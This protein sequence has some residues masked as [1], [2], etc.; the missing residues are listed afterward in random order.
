MIHFLINAA[1]E[2]SMRSTAIKKAFGVF[3]IIIL[4]V[5]MLTSCSSETQETG[6][7]SSEALLSPEEKDTSGFL[8]AVED[9]PDTVD[10]QCTSIHYTVALNVFD[11]L[12]ELQQNHDGSTQIVPSLAES[13]KVSDD[14]LN[15]SFKLRDNVKF[16]NGSSLTSSDV[17]YTFT[18]LLTNPKSCNKDI[19]SFIKGADELMQGKTNVLEGFRVIDDR[20]FVITLK[21]PFEAFFDCLCM[22]GASIMDE[23]TTKEAGDL[24]GIDPEYTV[25]TGPFIFS[26]WNPDGLILTANPDCFSGPP[27]SAGLDLRF[28]TE[29]EEQRKMFEDGEL[30]ILDLDEMGDSAEFFIHGDIYQDRLYKVQQIGIAYFALNESVEPLNDIRV[31]KALQLSLDRQILLDAVY[32]GRGAVENGIYPRGLKGYNPELP[33]IPFDPDKAKSL[34][35]EAGLEDG[36]DL[37]ISVKTSSTQWEMTMATLA[38]S[39]WSDIGINA[40]INVLPENEFMDLRKSGK[41][42]CYTATWIADYDDPDNF[43]YTFYGN[44][45]NTVFRSLCYPREDIMRKVNSAR[46]IRDPKARIKEYQALEETIVH[47]DA[48]WIPLFSRLRYYVMGENVKGFRVSWNGSVKTCY[49]YMSK[50]EQQD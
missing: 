19:V 16:S 37:E 33:E 44:R 36:F 1:K 45:E 34:L 23:E 10:F 31:R 48:A 27:K 25:G 21:E 32:S 49:R 41:I 8:V 15:Y 7:Q 26:E 50:S 9:E 20:N 38:S 29:A 24:F 18:R 42:A 2:E 13:F 6:L 3:L 30:D 14:G 46:T 47:D 12:V 35:R 5:C 22:P 39:M 28:L 4:S 17:L 40:Y 43:I 11:R